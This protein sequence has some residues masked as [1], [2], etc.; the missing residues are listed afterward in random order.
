[1]WAALHRGHVEIVK[2]FREW[3]QRVLTKLL[4]IEKSENFEKSEKFLEIGGIFRRS[5]KIERDRAGA[6][7]SKPRVSARTMTSSRF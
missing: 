1:M 2:L 4:E 7:A 3:G 5:G 6:F